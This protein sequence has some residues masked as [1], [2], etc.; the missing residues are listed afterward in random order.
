M[1]N[2]TPLSPAAPAS[3]APVGQLLSPRRRTTT[4]TSPAELAAEQLAHFHLDPASPVGAPL[5]RLA[6]KLYTAHGDLDELWQATTRTLATLPRGDRLA[7]FN[8]KKFVAFQLAKLLDLLQNPTRAVHQSLGHSTATTLAKGPYPTFDNVAALFS[9]NPVITRTATYIFACTE[10]IDDAFHG[11]EFLHE[12]YSRLLNPTSISL[13]NHIVDVEAGPLAPE[14]LA[15]NFNSGMAAIDTILS[16]LVGYEDIILTS[17][18]VYGGTYQLLHDWYAKASNLNVAVE[19]FDGATAADFGAA[20]AAAQARHAGRLAAGRAIYVFL[21]SP[22]NPHGRFLDVPAICRHAHAAGLTVMLDATVG[23]PFLVRPLQRADVVERPDFVIHSYTKDLTG[24]GNTTAGV[25]IGRNADMFLP[26][27]EPGW[28]HT[29][30]WNVYYIKGAFLDADKAYEVLTGMKT[31][32]LRML[33]KCINTLVLSRWLAAHPKIRV[34]GPANPCDPS[35]PVC[36]QLSYLGLPAPLFTIDFESAG[37]DRLTFE[38]FFDSLSPMFGHQVTLGQGNTVVLCPALT[39]HSELSPEALHAAGI[40]PTTIRIAVGD[41]DPRE[42]IRDFLAVARLALDLHAPGF[43]AAF[44]AAAAID[45]L[46]DET[47][48]D[49]HRRHAAAQH[50]F[51]EGLRD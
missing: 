34:N 31:L 43:S 10:W 4:A 40:A 51:G 48:I 36:A 19:F 49:I 22:C 33:K 21:E 46:V 42:L 8:A 1:R 15:W 14:Y 7:L 6:E 27:G 44:P 17:R 26:K 47:Y 35:A 37:L 18:N 12:I 25:V 20:L 5:Q 38:R 3:P 2:P 32:E 23:T 16:H 50:R 13:A 39:S 11:R 41:E 29:L 9:A 45:Q 28:E 24:S 30:F